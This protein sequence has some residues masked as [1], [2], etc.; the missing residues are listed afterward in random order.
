[1]SLKTRKR[2]VRIIANARRSMFERLED[3]RVLAVWSVSADAPS[4]EAGSLKHA[5]EI[6]L[7]NNEDDVIQLNAGNDYLGGNAT[8]FW[9]RLRSFFLLATRVAP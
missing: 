7:S 1:M 6:A 3:R 2:H 4:H 5:M 8:H 9:A